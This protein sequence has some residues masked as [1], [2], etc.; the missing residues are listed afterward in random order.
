MKRMILGLAAAVLVSVGGVAGSA[1]AAASQSNVTGV[2]TENSVAVAGAMVTGLCNGNTEVDGST[3][4]FGSYLLVFPRAQCPF[5]ST[6]KVTAKKGSK[7]GVNTGTVRGITTKLNLA[8]V[9][10][11]IP[12]M[13]L[14]GSLMA[15]GSGLG[16]LTYMRRRRQAQL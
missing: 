16:L 7:S 13:G 15:G 6:V 2:I 12:E 5:G 9:N 4:A 11:S 3:D 8:I 14:L 10:V 1:G